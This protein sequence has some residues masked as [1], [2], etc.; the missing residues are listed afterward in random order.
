MG[1]HG[2]KLI[3]RRNKR[4]TCR[5]AQ[6]LSD[7]VTE[8]RWRI[9]TCAYS[10]TTLSQHVN[11][12]QSVLHTL[13]CKPDLLCIAAELLTQGEGRCVLEMR[14]TCLHHGLKLCGLELQSCAKLRQCW[15]EGTV[16][17][18]HSGNVHGAG[19]R[20]I[21]AHGLVHVIVWVHGVLPTQRTAQHLVCS[22]RNHLVHIHVRLGAASSLPHDQREVVIQPSLQH[23][24]GSFHDM[25]CN[26]VP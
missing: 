23:L 4:Q 18:H 15:Q 24:R 16:H 22:I 12:L 9:E 8:P 25:V 13:L 21:G 3:R 11:S 20:I 17:L 19:K 26:L 2:L 10:C 14:P 1:G 6:P 5:I 7:G